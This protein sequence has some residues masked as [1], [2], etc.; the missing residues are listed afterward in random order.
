[1]P[2]TFFA[3][4]TG[5]RALQA[6]QVAL[7]VIGNNTANINT[8]GYSRQVVALNETDPYTQPDSNPTKP[9]QLGTGV[10]V[11]SINRV[12]DQFIDKRIWDA[13]SQQASIASLKDTLG[14]VETAYGEPSTTGIGQQMTDLF[15]SFSDL[16]AD[17]SNSAIRSTVQNKAESLVSTFHSV[18]S[19]LS[20]ITPELTSKINSTVDSVNTIA[21]QIA[22]LN[23]EIGQ[24]VAAGQQPND[25]LDKR[26]QLV[27]QLS[28]YVDVQVIDQK[29]TDTGKPTG[30]ININVGGFS[31]VQDDTTNTLPKTTM[32]SNNVVGLTTATGN[33][34]PLRGGQLYGL[35]KATTLVVGYQS[36]LDNLAYNVVNATNQLH[37]TGYSLDGTTNNAFF[38]PLTTATGAASAI[39]VDPGIEANLNKIAAATPPTPPATFAPGNGDNAQALAALAS[40]PVIG[41]FSLD[42]YYNAK[43]AGIGAASQTYQQQSDT[44]DKIV[45]QLQTQQS[46]VSGVNLDEELTRMLQ[47]QRAY[48][49][50]AKMVSTADLF[51]QTII[52]SLGAA[53]A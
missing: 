27:D 32:N 15:N 14:Q 20:A 4:E 36:D 28:G 13:T 19:A 18:N 9:G 1:M 46:S 21:G 48:Q 23:K 35:V 25:L 51:L 38:A 7:E 26:G 16:S 12:R 52:T 11:A 50:A 40:T 33:A 44:Q 29:N 8:P 49:A 3:L 2:S 5:S 39:I 17:P 43:V 42:S 53:T 47:Y 45:A 31:L 34:I 30:Q 6:S 10:T 22:A 37:K 24:S 41:N